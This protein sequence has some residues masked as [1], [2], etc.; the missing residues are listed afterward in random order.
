MTVTRPINLTLLCT[1]A[2]PMVM[3]FFYWSDE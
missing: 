3:N 2:N 1:Q